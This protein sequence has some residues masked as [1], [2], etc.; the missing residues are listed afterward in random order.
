[1]Q[2]SVAVSLKDFLLRCALFLECLNVVFPDTAVLPRF[3]QMQNCV[4]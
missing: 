2:C 1:M 4:K 3:E